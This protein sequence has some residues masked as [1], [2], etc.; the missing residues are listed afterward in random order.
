MN[1]NR[2]TR[3]QLE[4]NVVRSLHPAASTVV[5]DMLAVLSN[6]ARV[7]LCEHFVYPNN[8]RVDPGAMFICSLHP[9]SGVK[10]FACSEVHGHRPEHLR[11]AACGEPAKR[12]LE[13]VEMLL[14]ADTSDSDDR[15]VAFLNQWVIVIPAAICVTCSEDTH[16]MSAEA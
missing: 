15:P 3:F 7:R 12:P 2:R 1:G 4:V 6:L 10:C 9:R 11:C 8:L 5:A 14:Q 16:R 13:G